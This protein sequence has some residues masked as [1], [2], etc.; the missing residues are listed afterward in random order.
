MTSPKPYAKH[1]GKCDGAGFLVSTW[2]PMCPE[3]KGTGR[4][5]HHPSESGV[6]LPDREDLEIDRLRREVAELR[7]VQMAVPAL[8]MNALVSDPRTLL[9]P[10]A[11]D[12]EKDLMRMRIE[13]F[14]DEAESR[15]FVATEIEQRARAA[16]EKAATLQ[17]ELSHAN[18]RIRQMGIAGDELALQMERHAGG[19]CDADC[20]TAQEMV[21]TAWEKAKGGK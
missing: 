15:A 17:A 21:T 5:I 16:E 4:R 12:V 6:G 8:D 3:C 13:A 19:P 18:E 10:N 11:A 9:V 20:F 14:H 7:R 1:C 2:D